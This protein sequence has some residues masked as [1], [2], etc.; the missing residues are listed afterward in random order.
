M[1]SSSIQLE[2]TG[3]LDQDVFSFLELGSSGKGEGNDSLIWPVLCFSK[4]VPGAYVA[5][6]KG[7]PISQ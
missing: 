4:F 5:R 1:K 3:F 2:I 7:G 6:E